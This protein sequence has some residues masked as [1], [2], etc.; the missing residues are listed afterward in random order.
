[1]DKTNKQ[2]K[3]GNRVEI[4]ENQY[5]LMKEPSSVSILNPLKIPFHSKENLIQAFRKFMR[6]HQVLCIKFTKQ[7]GVVYQEFVD[8]DEVNIDIE[9]KKYT[10]DGSDDSLQIEAHKFLKKPCDFFNGS[11]I[12]IV[13]YTG[14]IKMRGMYFSVGVHYALIDM[15]TNLALSDNLLK[16]FGRVKNPVAWQNIF[17]YSFITSVLLFLRLYLMGERTYNTLELKQSNLT[18]SDFSQMQKKWLQSDSGMKMRKFWINMLAK[19]SLNKNGSKHEQGVAT[20]SSNEF[21]SQT[22]VICRGELEKLKL[23]LQHL[24][25]PISALFIAFH[26]SILNTVFKNVNCL[27]F[28][29]V[30]G[31]ELSDKELETKNVWGMISNTIPLPVVSKRTKSDYDFVY[32]VYIKYCEARMNQSVPIEV[33]KKDLQTE[34]QVDID[35]QAAGLFNL[36][37]LNQNKPDVGSDTYIR[38]KKY[39]TYGY[40][41]NLFVNLFN[42]AIE[43]ELLLDNNLYPNESGMPNLKSL[44]E[45]KFERFLDALTLKQI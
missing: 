5:A 1:M 13:A 22:L 41:V 18:N 34:K 23:K 45:N 15:H 27:Q 20:V 24:N 19:E 30:D 31:R 8:A 10:G 29:R 42:N 35:L 28:I 3:T 4:S 40:S 14:N 33:I 37:Q 36:V 12:R 26:Q 9:Y 38:E 32:E 43:I 17:I 11:F 6:L 7:N 16:F 44:I 25:L 2:L 39:N 21:D